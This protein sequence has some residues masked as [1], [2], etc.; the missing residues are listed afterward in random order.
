MRSTQTNLFEYFGDAP[1]KTRYGRTTHGGLQTKR[2][3]KNER[4]LSTKK[5]IHLVLKSKEAKGTL[6]FLHFKNKNVVEKIIREK[7]RKFGI[8][9]QDFANVGNHLHLKIKISSR[10]NF[11][12]FL[13]AITTLIARKVTGAKKGKPFGRPFWEGLAFTR[14]ITS[15]LQELNLKGYIQANRL[16]ATKSYQARQKYLKHFNAWV[17]KRHRQDGSQDPKPLFSG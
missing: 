14:I 17:Y 4:P 2:V 13:K 9:I 15:S 5:S 10:E 7:A 1:S 3:R 6:S 16:E 8:K 12:K 11:Q